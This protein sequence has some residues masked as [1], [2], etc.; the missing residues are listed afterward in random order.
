MSSGKVALVYVK[1]GTGCVGDCG[2]GNG[3]TFSDDDGLSW[4]KELDVSAGFGVA[5]GSLPGPGAGVQLRESGRLLAA[6]HHSAYQHVY[7][8]YSDDSGLTWKTVPQNFAKMDESTLAD[9]GNGEVLLNMRHQQEKTLGRAVSRSQDGGLTW[10][11][12]TYDKTLIGP[13]C[14]GSLAA[15]GESV[16]FSN[17]ADPGGRDKISVRRSDDGGKTWPV[18]L[19]IQ[20]GGSAGY[21][22]LV[23]G[24][25]VDASHSGLLY[26]STAG[27]CIDFAIFSLSLQQSPTSDVVV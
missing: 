17:P 7:I 18:S 6:S 4:S 5:S 9:L 2:T 11:N 21:S 19:V 12:I 26:E 14:Q 22:S 25:I 8:T 1:H 23:K 15:I 10:S 20:D 13:V 3:V 16:F 27:G 24:S